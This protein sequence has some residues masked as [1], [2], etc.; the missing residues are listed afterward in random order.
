MQKR[1]FVAVSLPK[2]IKKRLFRFVEKEYGNFPVKWARFENF[3]LT[4]N[5]LGYIPEENIPEICVSVREKIE[6]IQSFELEFEEIETGPKTDVQKMI[7]ATGKIHFELTEL[8]SQLDKALGQHVRGKRGFRP[9]ITLG[10]IERKKWEKMIP[11]PDVRRKFVFAVPVTSVELYES[12]FEKGKRVYYIL[13][14]FQLE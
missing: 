9:H 4:M 12:R 3:H 2:D 8:K 11:K 13:E 10:R 5:F 7:W 14:S 1:L 6:K